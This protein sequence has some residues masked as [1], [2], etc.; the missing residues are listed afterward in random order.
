MRVH[1]LVPPEVW[2][3]RYDEINRF[4]EKVVA[5][6]L[7]L[8]K[9]MLHISKEEQKK[10]LVERLTDSTKYWKYNPDD[11]AER[12]HWDDYQT[13]YEAALTQCNTESAPWHVVPADRKW[14]RNW[15]IAHLLWETFEELDPKYPEPDFD[16]SEQ[17]AKL[18]AAD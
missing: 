1:D 6:G 4:E 18:K 5:E 8:V 17:L 10:R 14:Y 11:L 16:V 9:V 13:A 7:T 12:A 3:K 15:A 2:S